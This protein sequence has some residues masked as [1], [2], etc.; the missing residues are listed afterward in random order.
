MQAGPPKAL[1]F[2]EKIYIAVELITNQVR[3]YSSHDLVSWQQVQLPRNITKCYALAHDNSN[4]FMAYATADE[5]TPMVGRFDSESWEVSRR[6]CPI[7]QRYPGMF[8]TDGHIIL[9][10][11][12]DGCSILSCFTSYDLER[13]TWS[14]VKNTTTTCMQPNIFPA[15]PSA[16]SQPNMLCFE[17]E[18]HAVGGGSV[19]NRILPTLKLTAQSGF[20]TW[21]E[22]DLPRL[23]T[24]AAV[25]KHQGW[26]WAAGG[27]KSL[28]STVA[29][30]DCVDTR[31]GEVVKMPPLRIAC[32]NPALVVFKHKLV[33][34]G[35]YTGD[36]FLN[37]LLTLD[38]SH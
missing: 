37:D 21:V 16:R 23:K 33:L 31:N 22:T 18:W 10:G 15:L 11:G 19:E 28:G 8:L 27:Y 13:H 6:P 3:L 26:L 9:A 38:L 4:I 35:G 12:E 17:N 24:F 2:Q 20:K 25:T 32:S 7:E 1:F 14:H 5:S 30:V 34:F 36:I 29:T